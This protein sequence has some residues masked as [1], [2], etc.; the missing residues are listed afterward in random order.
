[1]NARVESIEVPRDGGRDM[2]RFFLRLYAELVKRT[3]LHVL[4]GN[5]LFL[6]SQVS[7]LAAMLLPWKVLVILTTGA[8]LAWLPGQG[9]EQQVALLM[10]A[11]LGAFTLH[12][13]CQAG[14]AWTCGN[15]AERILRAHDKTGLFAGYRAHARA[16]S[17]KLLK[18]LAAAVFVIGACA[19]I[20]WVYPT[21]FLALA[22]YAALT[23]PMLR[24]RKRAASPA[25][26]PEGLSRSLLMKTWWHLGVICCLS[27][28]LW[29]FWHGGTPSWPR[30]FVCLL[31]IRQI[32]LLSVELEG[33]LGWIAGHRPRAEALFFRD[34]TWHP[35]PA[36]LDAGLET[37]IDPG[38]RETLLAGLLDAHGVDG[39]LREVTIRTARGGA[40]SY[41]KAGLA[42]GDDDPSQYVILKLSARSREA[43]A[44]HEGRLLRVAAPDWPAPR[45]L[46]DGRLGGLS[47]QLMAAQGDTAWLDLAARQRAAPALRCRLLA[48]ELPAYLVDRYDRSHPLLAHR[49]ERVSWSRLRAL[50]DDG[51]AREA[52]TLLEEDW[53][54]IL[55]ALAR[56]PRQLAL[57]A[58]GARPMVGAA[59]GGD[60]RI[61]DW[62]G[63]AWLPVGAAW[64][65][66]GR[67]RQEIG[68]AVEQA[69]A[70]RAA[71]AAVPVSQVHQSALLYAFEKNYAERKYA[72]ALKRAVDMLSLRQE[73]V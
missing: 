59:G 30:V 34:A 53:T 44:E 48:C 23:V 57:S 17:K 12:L 3:P 65:V 54:D 64:P 36:A 69:R 66:R 18:T 38:V 2:G 68:R 31:L 11:V 46:A 27:W 56:L 25:A 10:A 40:V 32:L 6:A 52:C 51:S 35:K 62:S 58:M 55:D 37:V 63:W 29:D 33:D 20:A 70:H 45:L 71:L 9:V 16:I 1:M 19:W 73:A 60:V 41:L 49:L 42:E 43:A 26:L 14:I 8:T 50:A 7:M 22:A 61:C 28:V 67:M 24:R 5:L 72:L 13:A 21:L 4:A 47:F 39:T 15:G